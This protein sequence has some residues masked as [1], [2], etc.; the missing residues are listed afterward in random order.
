MALNER[1]TSEV[2]E[3]MNNYVRYYNE[4][5][6]GKVLS[7][8][9]KTVSGFGTAKDEI[10]CNLSELR[11]RILIDLSPANAISMSVKILAT[12]GEMPAA[13]ITGLCNLDGRM[14]GKSIHMEGRVTAVLVNH[15][16]KWLFEQ[17]HFSV[18]DA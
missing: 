1:A 8:F 15:G 14:G 4:R 9:S 16:G 18:P 13:W 5:N 6:A 10:A 12:G 7:L 17:V 2:A 3:V 11:E